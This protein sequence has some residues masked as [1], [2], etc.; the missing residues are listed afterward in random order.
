[1]KS[2]HVNL[3]IFI[4]LKIKRLNRCQARWVEMLTV[5][6]FIIKHCPGVNNP[7]D[8]PS[9]RPDYE[10]EEGKVLED[11]LLPTLQEKLSR[12]LIKPEEWTNAPS[13]FKPLTV[14]MMTRSKAA[15]PEE[16]N[17]DEKP[18]TR[19]G[20][21]NA[22]TDENHVAG[23]PGILENIVPQVLVKEA[24]GTETTYSD[25]EETM[26]EFLICMQTKDLGT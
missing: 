19:S 9:Q 12:G 11:T 16:E 8:M 2:N 6:N 22:P 7:I 15:Q 14:G 13:E 21:R 10:P 4:E 18:D 5:F 20:D 3:Q 25:P 17:V 24:M 23:E 1:M 26:T